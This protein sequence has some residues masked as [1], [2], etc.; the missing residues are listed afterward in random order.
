MEMIYIEDKNFI[1]KNEIKLI[2]KV[3]YDV[4]TPWYLQPFAEDKNKLNPLFT[5]SIIRRPE[6]RDEDELFKSSPE[7]RGIFIH[8]LTKFCKKNNYKL[9]EMLRCAINFT[10]DNNTEKCGVHQDHDRP[11]HQL[12]IYLNEADEN[13]KTIVLDDDEKTVLKEIKPEAFK[14]VLFDGKPHYHYFP[15]KGFRI[16]VVYTFTGKL[17]TS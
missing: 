11:Y 8:L 16:V 1:D 12:L 5:H 6:D 14:G 7:H 15:K 10:F 2:N 17:C 13:A 4:N 3:L 9:D